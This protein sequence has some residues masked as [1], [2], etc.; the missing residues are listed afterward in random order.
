MHA[1]EQIIKKSRFLGIAKHCETWEEAQATVQRIRTEHAKARHICFG[2]VL[3]SSREHHNIAR[4]DDD[5]EPTGTAGAPILN[6]IQGEKLIDTLCVVVRYFGGVKLGAGGLIRAY[7]STARQVLRQAT[8]QTLLPKSTFRVQSSS[9]SN[10]GPIYDVVSRF[11]GAIVTDVMYQDSGE[12]QLTVTC[13]TSE[14]A[15]I[16]QSLMDGTRG[17][18]QWIE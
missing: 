3:M 9:A 12:F 18:I 1:S 17:N 14:I 10:A 13:D 15:Q 11:R 16:Q 7:G 5:N 8:I 2:V 4:F 6:A